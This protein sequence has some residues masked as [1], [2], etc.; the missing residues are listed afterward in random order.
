[1]SK[2]SEKEKWYV[3]ELGINDEI[4]GGNRLE[5]KEEVLFVLRMK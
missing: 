1:V 3:F 5:R 4:E 2:L